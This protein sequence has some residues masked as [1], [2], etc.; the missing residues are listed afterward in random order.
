MRFVQELANITGKGENDFL[1]IEPYSIGDALHTLGLL[2]RFR[3]IYCEPGQRII[4]LCQDRSKGLNDIM[5]FADVVVGAQLTPYEIQFE[6]VASLTDGLSPHM[7]VV[8]PPDMH[9]LGK[10]GRTGVNPVAAKRSIFFLEQHEPW[11][12]PVVSSPLRAVTE[13]RLA[14]LGLRR[15]E[16][17][18]IIPHAMTYNDLAP[19]FWRAAVLMIGER[20]PHLRLFTETTGG[21]PAIEGTEGLDLSLAELIP[22]VEYAGAA[23]AVRS[24][25]VDILAHARADIVS[26]VPPTSL[27]KA[28]PPSFRQ[29]EFF[30][31]AWYPDTTV[32]DVAV[33]ELDLESLN[34]VMAAFRGA[35]QAPALAEVG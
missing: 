18:F 13:Q 11:Q 7:P 2:P 33:R 4:L 5:P 19:E 8:C 27:H 1:F 24:G 28:P 29:E 22:A 34:A 31:N 15:G 3:E 21:R 10:I 23:L 20:F 35:A 6:Y 32:A 14:A 30:A 9:A 26:M 25:L 12:G 17:L 16:G